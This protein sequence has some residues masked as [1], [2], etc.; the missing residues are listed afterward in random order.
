MNSAGTGDYFPFV[1]RRWLLRRFTSGLHSRSTE[2]LADWIAPIAVCAASHGHEAGPS[3]ASLAAFLHYFV[4]DDGRN[5]LP[6]FAAAAYARRNGLPFFA[7]AAYA[8]PR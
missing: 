5:G 7:A 8:R 2:V 6:F 1:G 4:R 3:A